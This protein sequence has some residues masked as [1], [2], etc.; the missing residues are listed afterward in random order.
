M[1]LELRGVRL[2]R[3]LGR[4]K[5]EGCC[6]EVDFED[7]RGASIAVR[8]IFRELQPIALAL[9]GYVTCNYY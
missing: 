9:I 8:S 4:K 2:R 6:L 7:F 1:A 5:A 3:V